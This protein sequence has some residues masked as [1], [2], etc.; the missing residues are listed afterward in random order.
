MASE[1]P[2]PLAEESIAQRLDRAV[3]FLNEKGYIARWETSDRGY[4]IHTAN[5]PY[6]GIAQHHAEPCVMDMTLISELVGIAPQRLGWITAGDASCT[7]L[8]PNG[9]EHRQIAG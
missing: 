1:A 7:Y 5:C 4:L 6:R 3:S 8:V 2:R 9:V